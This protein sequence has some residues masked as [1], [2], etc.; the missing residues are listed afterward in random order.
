MS[1]IDNNRS[2]NY[3]KIDENRVKSDP[4]SPQNIGLYKEKTI[5]FFLK[6][7]SQTFNFF[8]IGLSSQNPSNKGESRIEEIKNVFESKG[9][10]EENKI[11]NK[12]EIKKRWNQ[13]NGI[14]KTEQ[15]QF[16]MEVEN[17]SKTL[18][19]EQENKINNKV[20]NA[21]NLKQNQIVRQDRLSNA[22][23]RG[24]SRSGRKH[25]ARKKKMRKEE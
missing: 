4:K 14:W 3:N 24:S 13:E 20:E 12:N 17:N 5:A 22:S 8:K 6:N 2:E 7:D 1:E 15:I 16:S 18:L 25:S 23:A 21:L 9:K 19:N 11:E 10:N